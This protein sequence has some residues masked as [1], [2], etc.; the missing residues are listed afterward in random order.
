MRGLRVV[1]VVVALALAVLA[2]GCVGDTPDKA[3]PDPGLTPIGEGQAEA[4]GIVTYVNLEGG[5]WRIADTASARRAESA[6]TVVVI[7][8]AGDLTNGPSSYEGRYVRATGELFDGASIR[9]AGQEMIV[10]RIE[11]FPEAE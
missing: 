9:M 2:T 4:V 6:G 10:D 5:F 11:I 8:N 3:L 7:A 1:M